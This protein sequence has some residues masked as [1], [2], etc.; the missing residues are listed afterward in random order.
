MIGNR[1]DRRVR[2]S[3]GGELDSIGRLGTGEGQHDAGDD[4]HGDEFKD[5]IVF[6]L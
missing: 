3:G 5:R 1:S 6:H 2:V 4:D